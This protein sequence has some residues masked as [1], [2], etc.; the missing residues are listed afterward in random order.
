MA[1]FEQDVLG[2]LFAKHGQDPA[3]AALLAQAGCTEDGG[4]NVLVLLQAIA[5]MTQDGPGTSRLLADLDA[6]LRSFEESHA[7]TTAT[8]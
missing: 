2:Y 4:G 6:S 8:R 3:L 1:D 5:Q 7:G